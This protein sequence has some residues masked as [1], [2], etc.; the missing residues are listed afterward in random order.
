MVAQASSVDSSTS[1]SEMTSGNAP[2]QL[3]V[4]NND[5]QERAKPASLPTTWPDIPVDPD[6]ASSPLHQALASAT[7]SWESEATK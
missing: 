2:E 1:L 7:R 4:P 6:W 5:N 3:P